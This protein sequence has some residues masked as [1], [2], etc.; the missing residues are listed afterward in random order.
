MADTL[1]PSESAGPAMAKVWF[2]GIM[3]AEIPHTASK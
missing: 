3:A 2:D 1:H